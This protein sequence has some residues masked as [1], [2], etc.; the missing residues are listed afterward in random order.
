[1][2]KFFEP[3]TADILCNIKSDIAVFPH[4][5]IHDGCEIFILLS[6]AVNYYI[7]Q[8]CYPLSRGSLI[9]ISP[10][11]YHRSELV[12]HRSYERIVINVRTSLL[13]TFSSEH[14]DLSACF[15]DRPCS[16]RNLIQLSNQDL[17]E[18]LVLSRQLRNALD[19]SGYGHDF[20][21]LSMLLQILVKSNQL[22]RAFSKDQA[23]PPDLM[24]ALVRDTMAYIEEHLTESISL[25]DLS[26]HF[27]HNGTYISRRFKA[28]TGLTIQQYI[29]YK[30]ISL[31][32]KYLLEGRSLTETCWMAGF[33]NYSNFSR[34]FS[35]QVGCSPKEYKNAYTP[36]PE[37]FDTLSFLLYIQCYFSTIQKICYQ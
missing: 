7:E 30:R 26:A 33:N 8:H 11:E 15:L 37:Y 36:P 5:H 3:L 35:H 20:L 31:A 29:L 34:S 10:Q 2:K 25:S 18:F 17:Q 23:S 22:Y 13:K 14:T 4:Y 21:A 16:E 19:E 9:M 27:F 12:D 1:M 6:G 28:V 32:Q 24:P